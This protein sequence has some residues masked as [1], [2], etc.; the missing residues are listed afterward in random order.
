M[1]HLLLSLALA[2][3]GSAAAYTPTEDYSVHHSRGFTILISPEVRAV[4]GQKAAA[5]AFIDRKLA[6]I[7]R[8][9][10][11]DA[12]NRLREVRIWVEWTQTE[13][14][15]TYHPSV[16][17]LIQNGYNPDKERSVQVSN[18][19]HFIDWGSSD[20]PMIL[21]H[22]LAHAYHHVVLG[23]EDPSVL[24]AYKHALDTDLYAA[25]PYVHGGTPR[26]YALT[27]EKEYFAELSE[28]YFGRNDFFPYTRDDL[29]KY[30]P[31][32]FEMI[33]RAWKAPESGRP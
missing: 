6:E 31:A 19:R 1:L 28:A 2:G 33:E 16:D 13:E 27:N 21:L 24:A 11:K 15:S 8:R 12:V 30:D 10:P 25:V 17:W 14:G 4:P 18:L 3:A 7:V 20:Q 5:L 29:R 22:E 26:A 32:G 9:V 23:Y